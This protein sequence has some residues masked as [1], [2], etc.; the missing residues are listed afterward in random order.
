MKVLMHHSQRA[1][2]SFVRW[3][4][5]RLNACILKVHSHS[6]SGGSIW[7][8]L[9]CQCCF[10]IAGGVSVVPYYVTTH[11]PAIQKQHWHSAIG[12]AQIEPPLFEWAFRIQALMAI[13]ML[14]YTW[15][16]GFLDTRTVHVVEKL[17]WPAFE[18]VFLSRKTCS[19]TTLHAVHVQLDI[20]WIKRKALRLKTF[21]LGQIYIV[22]HVASWNV[23]ILYMRA[24]K[25]FG[26]FLQSTPVKRG[27]EARVSST[28]MP[29][30]RQTRT[31]VAWELMRVEKQEFTSEFFFT[32]QTLREMR[33]DWILPRGWRKHASILIRI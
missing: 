24:V 29:C 28:L 11:P 1:A 17:A 3:L 14:K 6:K 22:P 20:K 25:I 5:I 13:R 18:L 4:E 30:P 8:S 12:E 23:R 33:V 15:R 19:S 10:W 32:C 21:P 2:R 7:A 31:R 26:L 9:E 16:Q 27:W